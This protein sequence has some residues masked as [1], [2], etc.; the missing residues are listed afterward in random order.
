ME[1]FNLESKVKQTSLADMDEEQLINLRNEIDRHLKLEIKHLNLTEELGLQYRQGRKLL[2][3]AH[4][5]KEIPTNQVSSVYTAV[6]SMLEKIVKM[7]EAVYSMERL[8]RYEAA[9]LKSIET[10]P[11][12]GK[13]QFFDLYGSFLDNK[14][15]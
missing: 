15:V 3:R 2:E 1:N 8:K 7:Q 14:G 10:L 4:N 9:F 13:E 11:P 12:E 5:D 6:S